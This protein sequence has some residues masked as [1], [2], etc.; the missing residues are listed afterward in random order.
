M[1]TKKK[2]KVLLLVNVAFACIATAPGKCPDSL[3]RHL[4]SGSCVPGTVPD[5]WE[6]MTD[7][8]NVSLF[9]SVLESV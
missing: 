7:E 1:I 4:V 6:T 9:S 5:T 8:T 2:G 3:T